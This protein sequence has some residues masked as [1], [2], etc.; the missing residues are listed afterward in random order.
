MI[1]G[2]LIE[3]MHSMKLHTNLSLFIS[4]L[5]IG[6]MIFSI[7][8]YHNESMECLNHT[9]DHHITESNVLCPIC[10]VT[11]AELPSFQ[12]ADVIIKYTSDVISMKEHLFD[13]P[14][15]YHISLRAP[16]ILT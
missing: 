16:P 15:P 8:H 6:G 9:E 14:A 4:A 5:L 3:T 12:Q 7:S 13:F 10:A 1:F 11:A 2:Y